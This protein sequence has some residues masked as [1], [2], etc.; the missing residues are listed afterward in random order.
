MVEMRN[1]YKYRSENLK[2]RDHSEEVGIDGKISEYIL[3]KWGGRLWTDSSGSGK[4]QV[5]DSNEPSVSIKGEEFL[6]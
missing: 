1:A 6:D 4:R 2:G 3:G 5:V